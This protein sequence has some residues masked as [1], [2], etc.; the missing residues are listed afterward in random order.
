MAGN[1]WPLG[2]EIRFYSAICGIPLLLFL[3][4]PLYNQLQKRMETYKSSYQH[5]PAT[6]STTIDNDG[7]LEMYNTDDHENTKPSIYP[8]LILL[9]IAFSN[10]TFAIIHLVFVIVYTPQHF[11]I[12]LTDLSCSIIASVIH[13][14]YILTLYFYFIFM[15]YRI[16]IIFIEPASIQLNSKVYYFC[17]SIIH[18]S[19][20]Y[21]VIWH[22]IVVK[23]SWNDKMNFCIMCAETRQLVPTHMMISYVSDTLII[24]TFSSVFIYKLFQLTRQNDKVN[25]LIRRTIILGLISSFTSLFLSIGV[26]TG[27]PM[28]FFVNFDEVINC[29][30]VV[31]SYKVVCCHCL[32]DWKENTNNSKTDDSE[33]Y[34]KPSDDVVMEELFRSNEYPDAT[35]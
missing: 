6:H 2:R 11:Q 15:L 25:E 14:S 19:L 22:R 26:L 31:F 13:T 3:M 8:A 18:I 33:D 23:M 12:T 27:F 4:Y 10:V 1:A 5:Q 24:T 34:I 21:K 16:R 28:N 7:N 20:I 9:L 35:I 30:C 32:H 29:Y 17:L